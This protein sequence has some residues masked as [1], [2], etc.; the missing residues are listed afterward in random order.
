MKK[1]CE[2]RY[3]RFRCI[4]S[5]NHKGDHKDKQGFAMFNVDQYAREKR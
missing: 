3:H 2:F 1:P 4:L 5:R